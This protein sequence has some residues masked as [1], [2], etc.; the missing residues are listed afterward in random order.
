MINSVTYLL[1]TVSTATLGS[2]LNLG[3][4]RTIPPSTTPTSG[5]QTPNVVPPTTPQHSGSTATTPKHQPKSPSGPDYSR[6]H[7]DTLNKN[8]PPQNDAKPKVKSDDVFGDLLGSQGYNFT[9]RKETAPKT[10]NAMRKEEMVTYMDPE[11]LKVMEWVSIDIMAKFDA[12]IIY[13]FLHY[14]NEISIYC[15]L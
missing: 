5:S 3:F 14:Y 1:Y 7:F 11:K 12:L 15:M 4:Q 13:L 8:Q 2:D 10:I 6:S 9:G